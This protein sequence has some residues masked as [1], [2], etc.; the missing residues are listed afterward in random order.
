MP[1]HGSIDLLLEGGKKG[2]TDKRSAIHIDDKVT[3][4]PGQPCS[5]HTNGS[6]GQSLDSAG[7]GTITTKPGVRKAEPIGMNGD[8]LPC[9]EPTTDTLYRHRQP[10]ARVIRH[11]QTAIPSQ[12]P[13]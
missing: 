5:P 4:P 8:D 6:E 3:R 9:G 2:V 7:K 11:R 1:R 12:R 10:Q 13:P